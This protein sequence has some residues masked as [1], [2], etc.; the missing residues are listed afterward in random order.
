M[1]F[2]TGDDD[3]ARRE[4]AALRGLYAHL[5]EGSVANPRDPRVRFL[6]G[7]PPTKE[8]I[9]EEIELREKLDSGKQNQD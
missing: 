9:A 2:Y 3:H 1:Q 8:N 4:L 7:K 5:R 6:N